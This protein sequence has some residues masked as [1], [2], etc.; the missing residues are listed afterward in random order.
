MV[1]NEKHILYL[2]TYMCV[3]E[4]MRIG[5]IIANIFKGRK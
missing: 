1:V 3:F 5:S 2:H 4:Y